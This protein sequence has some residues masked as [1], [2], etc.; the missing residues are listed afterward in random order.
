MDVYVFTF[1]CLV[2]CLLLTVLI[3]LFCC[4]SVM[5]PKLFIR[6]GTSLCWLQFASDETEEYEDAT[7]DS[8]E[9]VDFD[10]EYDDG[11]RDVHWRLTGEG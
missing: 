6:G 5:K 8:F 11:L 10:E 9:R 7:S 4:W 3:S 2:L 1:W